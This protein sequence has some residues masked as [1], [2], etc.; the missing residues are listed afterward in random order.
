MKSEVEVNYLFVSYVQQSIKNSASA[1]LKKKQKYSHTYFP[2][3]S[4]EDIMRS[5]ISESYL[6]LDFISESEIMNLE[7][8]AENEALS[9][10]IEQLNFKEKKLLYEKYIQ[11]KTDSEIARIFDI[12]RQ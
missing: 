6:S 11:C 1:C 8:F 2:T 4:L 10:A 9:R 3:D 7:N 5:S 12:S